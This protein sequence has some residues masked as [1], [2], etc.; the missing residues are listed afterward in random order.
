MGCGSS[1]RSDLEARGWK[2]LPVG[3][4]SLTRPRRVKKNLKPQV[5]SNWEVTQTAGR[6]RTLCFKLCVYLFFNPWKSEKP[7]EA[8]SLQAELDVVT[9]WRLILKETSQ[10]HFPLKLRNWWDHTI[11]AVTSTF[12]SFIFSPFSWEEWNLPTRLQKYL[13]KLISPRRIHWQSPCHF[14]GWSS[15]TPK[16]KGRVRRQCVLLCIYVS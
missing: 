3:L 15:G 8:P 5:C 13:L 11:S 9:M 7:I 2:A 6:E 4:G 1:N 12:E 16:R 10:G 14:H